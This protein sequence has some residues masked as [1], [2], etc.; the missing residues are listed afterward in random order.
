VNM[1]IAAQAIAQGFTLVTHDLNLTGF[2][3]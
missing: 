2:P 1:L 3:V